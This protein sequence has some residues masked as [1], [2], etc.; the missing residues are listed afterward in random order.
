MHSYGSPGPAAD[1]VSLSEHQ[2]VCGKFPQDGAQAAG[3][4]QTKPADSR[5]KFSEFED[6]YCLFKMFTECFL[7]SKE[8][9]TKLH[10][11]AGYN[12]GDF[13]FWAMLFSH[14]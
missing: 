7:V 1:G 6:I 13:G 2:P 3:I 14:F 5:D 4:R 9:T 11:Y 8:Y 10:T 12:T